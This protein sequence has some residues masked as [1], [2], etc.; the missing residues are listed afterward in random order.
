MNIP[1]VSASLTI[2]EKVLLESDGVRSLI[3]IVDLFSVGPPIPNLPEEIQVLEITVAGF[4]RLQPDDDSVRSVELHLIR[5]SGEE[6]LIGVVSEM[7][8]PPN[9][10]GSPRGFWLQAQFGL[11]PSEMG[12]HYL[13][14]KMENIEVARAHLTLVRKQIEPAS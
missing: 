5:P 7:S 8:A 10:H 11:V 9:E 14:A 1:L 4:F 12:V 3:R 6:R 13:S 2:C